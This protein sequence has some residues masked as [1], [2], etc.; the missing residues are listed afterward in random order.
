MTELLAASNVAYFNSIKVR[1]KH[2]NFKQQF[3]ESL[4]QFHK[5]TIK[6][7]LLVL[8]I[9][10]VLYFNSIKVRLKLTSEPIDNM[11][12]SNFNSIKVRLKQLA[13]QKTSHLNSFQF[14]KGTIK[15][16]QPHKK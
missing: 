9:R 13:P 16:C 8:S 14:H 4:F 7:V 1:L 6:T 10:I 2:S 12:A 3:E 11:S 5:G 15:T